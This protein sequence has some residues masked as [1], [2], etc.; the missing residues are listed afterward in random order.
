MPTSEERP[1]WFRVTE[2]GEDGMPSGYF[3]IRW[4]P[5]GLKFERDGQE[6]SPEDVGSNLDTRRPS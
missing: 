3:T 5:N 1:K 4:M 2:F 6:V